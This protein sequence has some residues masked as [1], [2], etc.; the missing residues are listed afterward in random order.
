MVFKL[1]RVMRKICIVTAG[2]KEQATEFL[3]RATVY[4]KPKILQYWGHPEKLKK[5]T[6]LR[7][8]LRKIQ[9]PTWS[10]PEPQVCQA[11]LILWSYN[12]SRECL[13]LF[14]AKWEQ[15][16]LANHHVWSEAENQARIK[17]NCCLTANTVIQ[18]GMDREVRVCKSLQRIPNIKCL[19][20]NT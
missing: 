8:L 11:Q 9:Q 15:V 7:P 12:I 20:K 2:I 13:H 10:N 4:A 1:V 14:Q 3:I 18:Y 19:V 16:N 17:D 5:C 6:G